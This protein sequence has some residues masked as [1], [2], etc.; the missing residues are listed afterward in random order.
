MCTKVQADIDYV[1]PTWDQVS[2]PGTSRLGLLWKPP[3]KY[4]SSLD[5]KNEVMTT[6]GLGW[7]NVKAS[8]YLS[9]S[10]DYC[11]YCEEQPMFVDR[12]GRYAS[13]Y[14]MVVELKHWR[15]ANNK[16]V[17]MFLPKSA[18]EHA[19]TQPLYKISPPSTFE[20]DAQDERVHT[21]LKGFGD[22][23]TEV[24]PDGMWVTEP[25]IWKL[26]GNVP[27]KIYG[28]IRN[29]CIWEARK[30]VVYSVKRSFYGGM[31][32]SDSQSSRIFMSREE[33]DDYAHK[34]AHAFNE[35][36][37]GSNNSFRVERQTSWWAAGWVAYGE[38]SHDMFHVRE[39]D[40]E[41]ERSTMQLSDILDEDPELLCI[42]SGRQNAFTSTPRYSNSNIG[43]C[44]KLFAGRNRHER[45]HEYMKEE[46]KD[47]CSGLGG[48]DY[49]E[50]SFA[51][52]TYADG[53]GLYQIPLSKE[54]WDKQGLGDDE[55]YEYYHT[56]AINSNQTGPT[57]MFKVQPCVVGL[58]SNLPSNL[59][60]NNVNAD[61]TFTI[62]G[63]F[64]LVTGTESVQHSIPQEVIEL[65]EAMGLTEEQKNDTMLREHLVHAM[66]MRGR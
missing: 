51:Y 48:D 3:P 27:V 30:P 47:R 2:I 25:T 64:I 24:R 58:P 15:L 13:D 56:D 11:N 31:E 39:H 10:N 37:F 54:E 5:P 20:Q 18:L 9:L 22:A 26:A 21:T 8:M 52:T 1:N 43:M 14:M 34:C 40:V 23:V 60:S 49:D 32:M 19:Y 59:S 50:Y 38:H 33:A 7:V 55:E 62:N 36:R 44:M 63:N 4:P 46:V 61:N 45:A 12:N 53:F 28:S 42:M 17:K 65:M 57:V 41:V 16:S 29:C 35:H 6:F 66:A